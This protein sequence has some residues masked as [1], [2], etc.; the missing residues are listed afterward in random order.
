[1]VHRRLIGLLAAAGTCVALTTVPSASEA[2]ASRAQAIEFT[3]TPPSGQDWFE[4]KSHYFPQYVASATASSGLPIEYS[5]APVS[6]DVCTIVAVFR[7]DPTWG[8]GAAINFRGAGTCT[9]W[10]D[11]PGN[12]DYLPAPRATQ[13]FQL[14]KVET[15]LSKVKARKGTPGRTPATFSATLKTWA[16]TSSF[17][18][19]IEPF[20]DQV[21]TFSVAGR[22]VCSG[23]TGHDGVAT[24]Q[25][26]LL[27]SDL[28]KLRFTATYAGTDDYEPVVKN[29]LFGG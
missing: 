4:G 17:T 25:A 13:S 6:A 27:R 23:T 29:A 24:C 3:S 14:E 10:A 16:A 12:G 28:L 11:Q 22:P 18:V 1:M 15:W 26:V 20:P 9:V 8:S 5:I 19:G 21:L 7:D 2:V